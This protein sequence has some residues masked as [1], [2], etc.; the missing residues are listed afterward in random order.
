MMNPD[1][2]SAF[3]TIVSHHL[4]HYPA[5]DI[6]DLY[7]LV[8]Q[9]AMGSEHAVADADRV[10]RRLKSEVQDMPPTPVDGPM[11]DPV[12]PDHRLVRVNLRPFIFHGGDLGRLTTAFINT[13]RM[14]TPSTATLG[15]YWEWLQEM[16]GSEDFPFSGD[17][18]ADY[19]GAQQAKQ[20]PAVHHSPGYRRLYHPAYRVVLK[21]RIELPGR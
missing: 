15:T 3:R 12:S 11:A 1:I 13:S 4:T 10:E 6:Q 14:F 17:D 16:A 21:N 9:A 8:F 5:L 19:G 18:L 2:K 20:Y 7:K